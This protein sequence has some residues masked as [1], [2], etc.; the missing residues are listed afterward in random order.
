MAGE[1]EGDPADRHR[2]QHLLALRPGQFVDTMPYPLAPQTVEIIGRGDESHGAGEIRRPG[3]E[4]GRR[5]CPAA[6]G[7]PL[8]HLID[9]ATTE[10]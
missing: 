3:L 6:L 8:A 10:Q 1:G 4:T 9:H 2:P 5:L 7:H